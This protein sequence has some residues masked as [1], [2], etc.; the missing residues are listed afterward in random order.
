M[1]TIHWSVKPLISMTN[2]VGVARSIRLTAES[3]DLIVVHSLDSDDVGLYARVL[4]GPRCLQQSANL[5]HMLTQ[6]RRSP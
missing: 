6:L 2:E 5:P 1:T 3:V 4:A